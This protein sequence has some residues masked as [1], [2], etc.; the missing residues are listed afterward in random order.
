MILSA[1][2][3]SFNYCIEIYPVI[4]LHNDDILF[5]SFRISIFINNLW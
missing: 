5:I 1:E 2:E 4:N 3:I